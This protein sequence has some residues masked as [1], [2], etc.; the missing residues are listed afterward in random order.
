MP[1]LTVSGTLSIMNTR[2]KLFGVLLDT[3]ECF[4]WQYFSSRRQRA[5]GRLR[6][7]LTGGGFLDL[8]PWKG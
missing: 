4:Q 3:R 1:Y 8:T 2:K 7:Q 5:V 6:S